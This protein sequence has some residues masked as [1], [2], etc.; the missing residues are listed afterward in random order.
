MLA[1]KVSVGFLRGPLTNLG[2]P[3]VTSVIRSIL[4]R[5]RMVKDPD[6]L[7]AHYTVARPVRHAISKIPQI[8]D[9]PPS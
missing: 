7:T 2:T 9:S 8:S 5:P 6:E 4:V 1:V 3:P